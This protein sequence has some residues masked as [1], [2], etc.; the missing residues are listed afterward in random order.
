MALCIGNHRT[1]RTKT[2]SVE[3]TVTVYLP[4]KNVKWSDLV[5]EAMRE[6]RRRTAHKD[7]ELVMIDEY[8]DVEVDY[9]ENGRQLPPYEV[10]KVVVKRKK[11]SVR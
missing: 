8:H 4:T 7:W 1:E 2:M 6:A 9:D 11:E 3:R 10:A 5:S